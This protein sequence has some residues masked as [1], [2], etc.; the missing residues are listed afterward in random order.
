MDRHAAQERL[1][2]TMS[3]WVSYPVTRATSSGDLRTNAS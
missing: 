3:A 2:M 1:A